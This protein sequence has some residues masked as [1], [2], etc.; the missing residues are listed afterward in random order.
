[1]QSLNDFFVFETMML[2][3]FSSGTLLTS[4]GWNTVLWVSFVPL[5][6]AVMALAVRASSRPAQAIG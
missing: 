6:V 4:Y 1:V 3:S 5:T 2:G